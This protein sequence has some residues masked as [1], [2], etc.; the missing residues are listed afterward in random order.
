MNLM[1]DASILDRIVEHARKCLPNEGC[2]LI[3]G[4]DSAGSEFIPVTNIAETASSEY[5][6]DPQELVN[7]LRRFRSGGAGL[8][9]I[10][11]SHP[12]GPAGLSAKDLERAYYPEA[13]HLI[14][15]MA[16]PERPQTAAF[17]IVGGEAIE[18]ELHVIV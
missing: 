1:L 9:A 4:R 16:N 2:G 15:S 18:V 17:R 14:V 5:E 10:F 8:V 6:M 12:R 11:H 13:A 7:G 3:G